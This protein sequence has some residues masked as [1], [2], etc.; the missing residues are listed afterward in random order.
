MLLA[1]CG[2]KYE[3]DRIEQSDW[4]SIKPTFPFGQVK[5][6]LIIKAKRKPLI[7]MYI[8]LKVPVLE[9]KSGNE[10]SVIAQSHAICKYMLVLTFK[11]SE[12]K[13]NA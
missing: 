7:W 8:F 11:L 10:V 2:Q 12:K 5:I 13:I 3:D 4:P 1:A 6:Y 9:I